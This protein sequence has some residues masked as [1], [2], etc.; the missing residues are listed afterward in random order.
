M[1]GK[2][3][4]ST[5][6]GV[7]HISLFVLTGLLVVVLGCLELTER[8][9]E[10]SPTLSLESSKGDVSALSDALGQPGAPAIDRSKLSPG[11]ILTPKEGAADAISNPVE[12]P[13]VWE[14]ENAYIE[15]QNRLRLSMNVD[16]GRRPSMRLIDQIVSPENNSPA[17]SRIVVVGDSYVWGIGVADLEHVWARRLAVELAA[18]TH[19][20]GWSLDLFGRGGRSFLDYA[21]WLS[22]ELIE[23]IDPEAIVVGWVTN[24]MI[25]SG[26]EQALCAVRP[27]DGE[28]EC[29]SS[30]E[31]LGLTQSYLKCVNGGDGSAIG[32]LTQVLELRWPRVSRWLLDRYCS[33]D[34]LRDEAGL[35]DESEIV[36]DPGRNPY[37]P[38]LLQA[39]DRLAKAADG[40]P[41]L[42]VPTIRYPFQREELAAYLDL[43]TEYG[44]HVVQTP[45]ALEYLR[46]GDGETRTWTNPGDAHPGP[47]LTRAFA[48]DTAD[49]LLALGVRPGSQRV[50]TEAM[51][52]FS[53]YLPVSLGTNLAP[54][55]GRFF[56]QPDLVSTIEENGASTVSSTGQARPKQYSPC[57]WFGRPHALL[58]LNPDRA[59]DLESVRVTLHSSQKSGVVVASARYGDDWKPMLGKQ[60]MLRPGESTVIDLQPGTSQLMIGDLT[61][62][63]A[64]DQ[65]LRMSGFTLEVTPA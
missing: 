63:C 57:A 23:K 62:G 1:T 43:F 29:F 7:R 18:R 28:Q 21:E 47:A 42:I 20:G 5:G 56:Q 15:K 49:A 41:V 14:R 59:V 60:V 46:A 37:L 55:G 39:M 61:T 48:A 13:L 64:V 32:R 53:N 65:E 22:P 25:P 38:L 58:G 31:E 24:D 27:S 40:R 19:T 6:S 44:F 50:G 3:G 36:T 30:V 4:R 17:G 54:G 52:L 9:L 51:E 33:A 11:R 16:E 35:V 12:D 10:P 45:R 8:K 34:R 2:V 26:Y